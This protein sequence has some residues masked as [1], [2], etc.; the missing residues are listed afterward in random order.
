MKVR[1]YLE[2]KP[3]ISILPYWASVG[4]KWDK[5]VIKGYA[6]G[7]LLLHFIYKNGK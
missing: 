5:D 4:T 6:F 2:L 7:W 3:Q 1:F